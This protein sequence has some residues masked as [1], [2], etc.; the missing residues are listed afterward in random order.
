MLSSIPDYQLADIIS[1]IVTGTRQEK[2]DVLNA[3]DLEVIWYRS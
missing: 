2:I 3:T 1:S